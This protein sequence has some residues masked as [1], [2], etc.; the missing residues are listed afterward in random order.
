MHKIIIVIS[1]MMKKLL[2]IKEKVNIYESI[3]VVIEYENQIIFTGSLNFT[4]LD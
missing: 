3:F 2:Q 1:N 4:G